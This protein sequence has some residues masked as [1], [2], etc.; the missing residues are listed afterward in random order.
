MSVIDTGIGIP[1]DKLDLIFEEFSQADNSTT[2]EYGGTG[3][4]LSLVKRFCEMMGGHISVESIVGEGST[5]T[6]DLPIMVHSEGP[7]PK[8]SADN[9]N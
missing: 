1:E 8:L 2:K 9:Q 6:I 7:E 5:F 3:L 4:S